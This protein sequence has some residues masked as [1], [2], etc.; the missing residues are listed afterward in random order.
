MTLGARAVG[1]LLLVLSIL[2]LHSWLRAPDTGLAGAATADLVDVTRDFSIAGLML[3]AAA[4]L[5]LGRIWD[6][7]APALRGIAQRIIA[8]NARTFAIGCAAIAALATIVFHYVVLN[9]QPNLIDTTAQLLHARF[10]AEGQLAAAPAAVSPF[11]HIQ[12]TA[13]TPSGWLSQYP[14]AQVA[15]LAIGTAIGTPALSGFIAAAAIAFLTARLGER[16]VDPLSARIGALLVAVS[17]FVIAHAG[18]FMSHATAAALILLA[19]HTAVRAEFRGSWL[20]ITGAALGVLLLT[21]P[22]TAVTAGLVIVAFVIAQRTNAVAS[23]LRLATGAL[24]FALLLAW[25]NQHFFGSATSFGYDWTLGEQAGLGFGRDPWGNTYG[26]MQAIAY[27]SAELSALN[28]NLLESLLPAVMLIG[29]YLVFAPEVS[30]GEWL[31]IALATA[32]LFTHLFY[33]HHGLFMGPRMLNDY[34]PIW[35]L[36]F[37]RSLIAL[38]RMASDRAVLG[39]RARA[40]YGS[41]ALAGLAAMMILAPQR[42]ASYAQPPARALTEIERLDHAVVFVHGSWEERI[43]MRLAASGMS[44]D[45]V[46]T[47]L[48][49]NETCAVHHFMLQRAEGR[50]DSQLDLTPRATDLPRRVAVAPGS[51]MRAEQPISSADC[52]REVNADRFGVLDIGPLLLHGVLP[53]SMRRGRIVARD[54]GPELNAELIAKAGD[55]PVW[56]LSADAQNDRVLLEPYASG[57]QRL[58]AAP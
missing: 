20:F 40:L 13:V 36:L 58:W 53:G 15:L 32:P 12:Q 22:L 54:L 56:L 27:T 8:L 31:L 46:E 43:G 52:V 50:P 33:W 41:A 7:L 25:Y 6:R 3:L 5:L 10:L 47:A 28:L 1:A 37:A 24:P 21:R 26:P 38:Y 42:L 55:R 49:Q 4:A 44:L 9:G 57:M 34:A 16:L 51:M 35:C 39:Y 45:S 2:P 18:A 14:P 30:R 17:P 29:L 11:W 19:A 48:R 23:L